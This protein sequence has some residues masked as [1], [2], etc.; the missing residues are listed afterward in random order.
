MLLFS[1]FGFGFL[2]NRSC[3]ARVGAEKTAYG[4]SAHLL[5]VLELLGEPVKTLI[6]TVT[7][8]GAGGLL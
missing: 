4:K 6:E 7:V 2:E 5:G 8:G 3:R 1:R